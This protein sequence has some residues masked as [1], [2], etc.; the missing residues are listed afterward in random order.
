VGLIP[1]QLGEQVPALFGSNFVYVHAMVW[2]VWSARMAG[3]RL[4]WPRCFPTAICNQI[5]VLIAF[6]GLPQKSICDR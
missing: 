2:N 5:H 3:L 4:D 1:V 6:G